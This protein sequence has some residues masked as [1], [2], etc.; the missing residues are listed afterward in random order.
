MYRS[1]SESEDKEIEII[2]SEDQ[3]HKELEENKES[4]RDL[5]N[6]YDIT[7]IHGI[8]IKEGQKR[9]KD[10]KGEIFWKKIVAEDFQ[11]LIKKQS[12]HPKIIHQHIIVKCWRAKVNRKYWKQKD[13]MDLCTVE[14]QCN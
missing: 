14:H 8:A 13:K 9:K 1:I 3:W 2:Q 12:V 7:N 4:L 11:N 10:R 6:N 5:W